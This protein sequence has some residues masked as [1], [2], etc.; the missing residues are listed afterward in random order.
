VT[1]DGRLVVLFDRD[2]GLCQATVRQL[3]RWDRDGSLDFVALQAAAS[4][5][6]LVLEHAAAD[7]RL[8]DSLHVID[9]ASGATWVGGDAALAIVDALPGGWMLRPWRT[10]APWRA[11]VDAGYDLVARNRHVL[12]H[13]L[14]LHGPSC[15]VA[16]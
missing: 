16:I 1:A 2:C 12:G 10:L 3:T 4:S 9:E 13:A 6:R 11:V 8:G 7:Y 5:G 15:E 14:G